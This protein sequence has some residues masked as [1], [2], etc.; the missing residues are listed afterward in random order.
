MTNT[1]TQCLCWNETKLG[2]CGQKGWLSIMAHHDYWVNFSNFSTYWGTSRQHQDNWQLWDC[3]F[4]YDP[5]IHGTPQAISEYSH[6]P[7]HFQRWWGIPWDTPMVF[8]K[9]EPASK[10]SR[11]CCFMSQDTVRY[12][13]TLH[14]VTMLCVSNVGWYWWSHCLRWLFVSLSSQ[15]SAPWRSSWTSFS[16]YGTSVGDL[17]S[18]VSEKVD[19]SMGSLVRTVP[20]SHPKP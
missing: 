7:C 20:P 2:Q 15:F 4:F 18:I 13:I 16:S 14:P 6:Q 3:C 8:S 9:R 10:K 5:A 17:F 12:C 19:L 1:V 11:T